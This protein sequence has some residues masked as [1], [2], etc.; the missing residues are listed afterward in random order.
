MAE[1]RETAGPA[2]RHCP[3]AR[4]AAASAKLCTLKFEV[5]VRRD[6]YVARDAVAPQPHRQAEEVL[7]A[8]RVFSRGVGCAVPWPVKE[9]RERAAVLLRYQAVEEV[10]ERRAMK[11]MSSP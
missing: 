10:V 4:L 8:L 5:A 7:K 6:F 1:A 9:E 11:G 2:S 3:E